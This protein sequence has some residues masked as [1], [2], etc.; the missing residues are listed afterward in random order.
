MPQRSVPERRH[1]R[2]CYVAV[3]FVSIVN[4]LT[5][6]QVEADPPQC[7]QRDVNKGDGPPQLRAAKGGHSQ[8]P[9]H[10]PSLLGYY[11]WLGLGLGSVF[12]P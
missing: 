2:Q 3:D 4:S 6:V 7:K 10:E 9:P 5:V 8:G 1:L 12:W 11:S